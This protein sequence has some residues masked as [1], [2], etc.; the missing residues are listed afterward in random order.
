LSRDY[1]EEIRNVRKAIDYLG[2]AMWFANLALTKILR[3][4]DV[5][6]ELYEE[7]R[8]LKLKL[9]EIVRKKLGLKE[10]ER[11]LPPPKPLPKPPRE[12]EEW[13]CP[14]CNKRFFLIHEADGSHKFEEVK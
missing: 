13:I 14:K 5:S 1:D 2:K 9:M 7:V 11:E 8:Q 3:D 10:M 6:G 12:I 4:P